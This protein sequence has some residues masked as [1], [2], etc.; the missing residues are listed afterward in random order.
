MSASTT[1]QERAWR[2]GTE[3]RSA[4]GDVPEDPAVVP[5]V[6]GERPANRFWDPSQGVDSGY[7]IYSF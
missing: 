2:G 3:S 6:S 7:E 5:R 1:G 4:K